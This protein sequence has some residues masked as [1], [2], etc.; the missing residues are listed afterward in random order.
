M[1]R[2]WVVISDGAVPASLPLF[3]FD[4]SFG[5]RDRRPFQLAR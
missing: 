4:P 5:Q 1:V 2:P 3:P